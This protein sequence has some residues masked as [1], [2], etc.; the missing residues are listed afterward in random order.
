MSF[1]S[2]KL[3]NK[4][5][6][7]FRFEKIGKKILITGET[8]KFLFLK[9]KDF[10]RFLKGKIKKTEP[11]YQ[12]LLSKGFL[13]QNLKKE[14][15]KILLS[16][17]SRNS[18]LLESGPS[19]HIIV[20]TLR[21][22]Y[23]CIYCQAAPIEKFPKNPDMDLDTAKATVDF[24]FSIKNPAMSIEFQG[25]EPLANWPIVK[26]IIKYARKKNEIAKKKLRIA[27]VSN[28][29]LLNEEK[30]SFLLKNSVAIC[31]SLDGPRKIHNKNRPCPFGDS[32]YLTTRWIKRLKNLE[33]KLNK[34]LISALPT[35]TK[36]S[37]E[38]PKEIV[39]EYR[40][41][42]FFEIHLRPL[43]YF[44]RAKISKS[45]LYYSPESFIKFWKKALNYMIYLN[46]KGEFVLERETKIMLQK[47][48]TDKNPNYTDL[49][50]PCGA[51][52][53]QI[54]YNFDG[55][56]LTCD[57]ARMLGKESEKFVL[58]DV[59]KN[60]FLEIALSS[61]AKTM[62]LASCLESL[63]CDLCVFKPYCGVCPVKNYAYYGTLFP[64]I[65]S[66]DWCKIKK[67]Q[68]EYIFQLLSKKDT[69]KI[70]NSWVKFSK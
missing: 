34:Y 23:R 45:S 49:H 14:K 10:L 4:N 16:F 59:K 31:T 9:E 25:G 13:R 60:N 33:K 63:S 11:I 56:I 8:G 29:S 20:P 57:E 24:I 42:G 22:N 21:C 1:A 58:G 3:K 30:L 53:G 67:A 2:L 35:I 44:G 40:K 70:L 51:V 19:L 66:T 61:K 26:F 7:F 54:L 5:L 69:A 37:L 68:F 36:F 41:W 28:L 46:K 27:L 47:I 18:N 65:P 6:P 12:E 52:F 15:Q 43:S 32:Y 48:L 64:H 39:D 55:K 50:S 62:V 38:Y 17:L